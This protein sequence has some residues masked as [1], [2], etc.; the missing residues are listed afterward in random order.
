MGDPGFKAAVELKADIMTDTYLSTG[1]I[2]DLGR[3]VMALVGELWVTRDRL[4]ALEA[5]LGEKEIIA[6]GVLDDFVP[7]PEQ[8]KSLEVMRDRLVSSVLGAPIAAHERSV[9]DI[10]KRAGL[11]ARPASMSG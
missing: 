11:P 8:A 1:N 6:A 10:L 4:A 9:D 3:M 2:D 7:S 5:L